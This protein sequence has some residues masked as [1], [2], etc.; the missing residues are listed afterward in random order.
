[1]PLMERPSLTAK[2]REVY[3]FI[4]KCLESGGAPTTREMM[5]HFGISSPNG[6]CCHI[7]ALIEKGYLVRSATN[8]ARCLRLAIKPNG[9]SLREAVGQLFHA[10]DGHGDDTAL[11][12]AMSNLRTVYERSA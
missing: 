8:T 4:A 11:E 1:M 5:A 3:N 9:K 10:Y 12:R 2:Q 6:I 7:T